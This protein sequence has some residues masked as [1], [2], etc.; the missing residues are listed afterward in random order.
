[1]QLQM[2]FLL[3]YWPTRATGCH[4]GCN[5]CAA[6][7]PSEAHTHNTALLFVDWMCE[8]LLQLSYEQMLPNLWLSS[9]LSLLLLSWYISPC[10]DFISNMKSSW[11]LPTHSP[12]PTLPSVREKCDQSTL[13]QNFQVF[14]TC[15]AACVT[16][17][18]C[19]MT[20]MNEVADCMTPKPQDPRVYR[21][22]SAQICAPSCP[23]RGGEK[24]KRESRVLRSLFCEFKTLVSF[25]EAAAFAWLD[26]ADLGLSRRPRP[27]PLYG[28]SA[29]HATCS[30]RG[31]APRRTA[32]VPGESTHSPGGSGRRWAARIT[33]NKW[34]TKT[35]NQPDFLLFF[36]FILYSRPSSWLHSCSSGLESSCVVKS[37]TQTSNSNINTNKSA[38]K[39]AAKEIIPTSKSK[40]TYR[41]ISS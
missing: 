17:P 40:D 30:T 1:M 32:R 13:C 21:S 3:T 2:G 19:C 20:A 23:S 27:S 7:C 6:C 18:P 38:N 41:H 25:P 37:R 4:L 11:T 34:A 29:S 26:Q 12:L 33:Q 39:A 9:K 16:E 5:R 31:A 15:F 36:F 10:R 22:Y 8:I 14:V 35:F 24:K 28:S